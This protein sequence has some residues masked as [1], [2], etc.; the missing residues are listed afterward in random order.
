MDHFQATLNLEVQWAS[1]AVI[2]AV[3]RCGGTIVTSYYD[4]ISLQTAIDPIS[5][6]KR[7]LYITYTQLSSFS[8]LL[9]NLT[10]HLISG[11]EKCLA[12]AAP[13][14]FIFAPL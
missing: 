8:S 2:A 9:L 6:F 4:P 10:C 3:E 1:E 11:A 7:G 14:E 13:P 5:H 12:Y